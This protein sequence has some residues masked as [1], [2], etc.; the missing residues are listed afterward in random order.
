MFSRHD[1]TVVHVN[2]AES[3]YADLRRM[4]IGVHHCIS[5]QHLDRY[6]EDL[7]FRRSLRDADPLVGLST[8]R[9][10]RGRLTYRNLVRSR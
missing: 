2:T 3:C 7:A 9:R 1:G 4:V 5:R 10:S 8:T 6:L